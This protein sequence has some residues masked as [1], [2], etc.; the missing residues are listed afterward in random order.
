MKRTNLSLGPRCPCSV[1]R[2]S[3]VVPACSGAHSAIVVVQACLRCSCRANTTSPRLHFL[4]PGFHTT[5]TPVAP[6]SDTTLCLSSHTP[7]TAHR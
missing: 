2:S 4:R 3:A 7:D 1:H 6:A 5:T